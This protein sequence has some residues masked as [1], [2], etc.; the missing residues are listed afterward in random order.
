M[1]I[2]AGNVVIRHNGITRQD[3]ADKRAKERG[4]ALEMVKEEKTVAIT[5]NDAPMSYKRS[6]YVED[7]T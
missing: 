3:M 4:E 7:L 6:K 1:A 5:V 2:K